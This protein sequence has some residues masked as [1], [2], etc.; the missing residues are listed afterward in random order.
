V[1]LPESRTDHER[2]GETFYVCAP[3]CRKT[4]LAAAAL[5]ETDEFR[6]ALGLYL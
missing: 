5:T 1:R 2:N 4:F 6:L 3:G